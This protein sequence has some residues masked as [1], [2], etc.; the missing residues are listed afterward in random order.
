MRKALMEMVME[1]KPIHENRLRAM[2]YL[3]FFAIKSHELIRPS[4]TP[5]YW[6]VS[7]R[8]LEYIEGKIIITKE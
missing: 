8:G 5:D 3:F 1:G 2:G 6:C 4:D 7:Q